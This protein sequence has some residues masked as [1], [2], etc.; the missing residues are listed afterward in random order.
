[1]TSIEGDLNCRVKMLD[2]AQ[3]STIGVRSAI[4][5][6]LVMSEEN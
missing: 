4:V 6:G 5:S 1:M 3:I 2:P